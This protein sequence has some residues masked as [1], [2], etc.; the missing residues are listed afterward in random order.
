MVK[1]LKNRE[2]SGEDTKNTEVQASDDSKQEETKEETKAQE[3]D[4]SALD[5][6]EKS[7]KKRYGD[8]RKHMQDKEKEW[9]EK[10]EALESQK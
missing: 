8:I 5:A 4:D 7:F 6:E 3:D 10:L 2:S 9:N 1:K